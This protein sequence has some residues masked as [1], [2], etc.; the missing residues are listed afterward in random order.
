VTTRTYR[1]V[2]TGGIGSGKSA[3]ADRFAALG[4]GVV[5]T[6]RI[7]HAL[8]GP[9]GE[10]LTEIE[11]AFGPASLTVDGG[12]D[13]AWMRARVFADAVERRRLEAILHPRILARVEMELDHVGSP[14]SLVVVPLFVES[15]GYARIAERVLVVDC[16][17][18]IQIERVTR[19]N[20]FTEAQARAIVAAQATRAARLAVAD[21][22]IDN[23]GDL[24]RLARAV[25]TLHERYLCL[26]RA[27][28]EKLNCAH[29]GGAA[30]CL[31]H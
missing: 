7:A 2:L 3:V 9:G 22:I 1:V 16:P 20:G 18:R 12:L 27:W 23:S 11:A 8:T 30:K 28:R 21:D 4:V 26:A 6:D 5:D 31:D 24:E 25:T 13:R 19:R 17:A 15:S 29:L 10:A 14:Y